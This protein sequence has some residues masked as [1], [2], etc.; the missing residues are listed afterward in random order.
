MQHKE[1]HRGTQAS[2]PSWT[3]LRASAGVLLIFSAPA[4]TSEDRRRVCVA[5]TED[6]HT[7]RNFDTAVTLGGPLAA[8]APEA[9]SHT[10]TSSTVAGPQRHPLP[11]PVTERSAQGQVLGSWPLRGWRRVSRAGPSSFPA[12]L[13]VSP[14]KPD[15][16][17]STPHGASAPSCDSEQQLQNQ[18]SIKKFFKKFTR[19]NKNIKKELNFQKWGSVAGYGSPSPQ[20]LPQGVR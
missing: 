7:D 11:C 5:W 15:F 20:F 16:M 4:L 6:A 13:L 2:P 1:T 8:L 12:L 3:F 9:S 10:S 14:N 18:V 17:M 19:V